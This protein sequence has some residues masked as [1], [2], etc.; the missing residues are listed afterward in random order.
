MPAAVFDAERGILARATQLPQHVVEL[1]GLRHRRAPAMQEIA[2]QVLR[3]RP[4]QRASRARVRRRPAREP[5]ARTR[6]AHPDRPVADARDGARARGFVSQAGVFPAPMRLILPTASCPLPWQRGKQRVSV[7]RW[8]SAM[9]KLH[10]P[11]RRQTSRMNSFDK[12]P[13]CAGSDSKK[14]SIAPSPR[15]AA[16][17]PGPSF[18]TNPQKFVD[19]FVNNSKNHPGRWPNIA[20]LTELPKKAAAKAKHFQHVVT[21]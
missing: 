16:S 10:G 18:D 1:H 20:G 14:L 7:R 5:P 12:V 2:Q 9:G 15:A 8:G 6:G 17:F 11:Y 19:N 4:R 3:A 21:T 13:T